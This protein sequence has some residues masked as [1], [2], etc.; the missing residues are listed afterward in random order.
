MVLFET[1]LT[2]AREDAAGGVAGAGVEREDGTRAGEGKA[3]AGTAGTPRAGMSREGVAFGAAWRAA[4]FALAELPCAEALPPEPL[5]PTV[6]L[7]MRATESRAGR[8]KRDVE[9]TRTGGR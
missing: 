3:R 1:P 7:L 5:L 4:G 2:V 9:H 6:F 8:P